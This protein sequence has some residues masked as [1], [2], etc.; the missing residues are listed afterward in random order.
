MCGRFILK[1]PLVE[2]Q[3]AFRFPERPNVRSRYNVAPSQDI[4]IV[5]HRADGQG[6]ELAQVRWGLIPFWAKD[7]KIAYRTINARAETVATSGTFRHA[8]DKRRCLVLADGFYE[9]RA[10]EG[11]KTKQPMMITLRTGAPFAF[12][13][14][15]E[16]WKGPEGAV[17]S[18]TII[19]TEPN[20]VMRPIHNRMPVLLDAADHD[21]WLDPSHPRG[22]D[23]LR[24]CPDD[25]LEAV[26]VSTRVN[27]P[28][29]DD[30]TLIRIEGEPLAAR[31]SLL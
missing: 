3:R 9:W 17:Q 14:L 7:A 5:R 22:A 30:E 6:R 31:P 8:F 24:P 18:A 28:R 13:G 19:T 11:Q 12:A 21:A 2:L 29:N 10:I 4:A 27:S 26:P 25:V 15:W 16:T 1:T 20:E 23:L